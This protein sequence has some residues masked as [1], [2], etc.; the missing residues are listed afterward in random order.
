MVFEFTFYGDDQHLN[1]VELR[2]TSK[3]KNRIKHLKMIIKKFILFLKA[4]GYIESDIRLSL[5]INMEDK[6]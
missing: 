2:F 5:D 1:K 6:L 4:L 3:E